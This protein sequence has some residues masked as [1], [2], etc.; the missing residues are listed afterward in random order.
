L[1]NGISYRILN[2][3]LIDNDNP[4][5]YITAINRLVLNPGDR[6][7]IQIKNSFGTNIS[8][9]IQGFISFVKQPTLN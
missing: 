8:P 4:T 9:D 3:Y 6:I 1:A 7:Q 2:N 5:K